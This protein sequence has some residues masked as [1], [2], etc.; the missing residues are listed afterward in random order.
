MK[1]TLHGKKW[2][3]NYRDESGKTRRISFD[4]LEDANLWISVKE[5][6]PLPKNE[7]SDGDIKIGLESFI[8][9]QLANKRKATLKNV[10]S[11]LTLALPHIG[12]PK[13]TKESIFAYCI[14]KKFRSS[15]AKAVAK[16][17]K[18][19]LA[20]HNQGTDINWPMLY[21]ALSKDDKKPKP[22][23]SHDDF[24]KLLGAC[25]Q[26][27]KTVFKFMSSNGLRV[28]ELSRLES[29]DMNWDTWEVTLPAGK[30]KAKTTRSSIVPEE[31]RED[32]LKCFPRTSSGFLIHRGDGAMISPTGLANTFAAYCKK[33]GLGK[34]NIHLLRAYAILKV[35][36]SSGGNYE[37]VRKIC[38]WSS[39]EMQKYVGGMTKEK[40]EI[41]VNMSW[42]RN[43]IESTNEYDRLT[44]AIGTC[45]EGRVGSL[46][47]LSAK[48]GI[49]YEWL[50][51]AVECRRNK[52]IE[53]LLKITKYLEH[54]VNIVGDRRRAVG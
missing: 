5:S 40:Q 42:N 21:R 1:A 14:S 11:I 24:D 18:A 53:N 10:R 35:L 50:H 19:Y 47:E 31:L 52:D 49:S 6:K 13:P 8:A 16:W 28:T 9:F 51:Q 29:S 45:M 25:S 36:E 20:Y 17:V 7:L 37:V 23:L 2:S 46:R 22:F 12:L 38:G 26:W 32:F 39:E 3:V 30:A 4:N 54:K 43:V 48:T 44:Q 34:R 33:A 27:Y 15:T 41:A